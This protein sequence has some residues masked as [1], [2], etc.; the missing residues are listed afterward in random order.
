MWKA[1]RIHFVN[2]LLDFR[3]RISQKVKERGD[4]WKYSFKLLSPCFNS[5][6]LS[7]VVGF[8]QS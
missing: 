1:N 2:N 8:P 6:D 7:A 5:W 3:L 4:P